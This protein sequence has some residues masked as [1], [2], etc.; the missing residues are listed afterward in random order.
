[1]N[2]EGFA[3]FHWVNAEMEGVSFRHG[4][5]CFMCRNRWRFLQQAR[6]PQ[7]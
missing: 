4:W 6:R 2:G 1:M 5:D 7:Q 3:F